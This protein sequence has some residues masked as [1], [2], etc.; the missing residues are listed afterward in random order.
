MQDAKQVICDGCGLAAS[1]EHIARRLK[2]LEK[3]TR[4]RPIHVHTLILGTRGPELDGAHLYSAVGEFTGEGAEVL[5]A[6]GVEREGRS[7]EATLAD[8]Q[9]KG[10]L[11]THALE[12]FGEFENAQALRD[13]IRARVP[14]TITRIRRSYRPKRLVLVGA[15]LQEFVAK[16]EA[17]GLDATLLLRGG[18][19]FEWDEIA[20]G[21]L[22]KVLATAF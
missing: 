20:D 22:A 3:M 13:A 18:K 17:A 7:V 9:R 2:R 5:R 10:F 14:A 15:E 8:F 6:A 21:E 16:F 12:C 11:V 1:Q 4:Y 19:P